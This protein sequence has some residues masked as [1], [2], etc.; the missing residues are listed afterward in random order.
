[1]VRIK[2][3][4][5]MDRTKDSYA[6]GRLKG[7]YLMSRIKGMLFNGQDQRQDKRQLFNVQD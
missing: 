5:S 4:Y 3:S 6:M 2:D 7:S 1:M